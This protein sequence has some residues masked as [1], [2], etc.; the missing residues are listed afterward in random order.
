MVKAKVCEKY[1]AKT[2]ADPR[3][4]A[5]KS[6]PGSVGKKLA[7]VLSSSCCCEC[8]EVIGEDTKALQC[9]RCTVETWKCTTC[10]G[11][12]DELYDELTASSK[13]GLHWFCTKCEELV[14]DNVSPAGEKI[15]DTLGK[16]SDKTQGIEQR[17][18]ENFDLIELQ[19]VERINAV[20]QLLE[21]K[22]E[23]DT[24]QWQLVES[25]LKKLEERPAVIEEAQE[26]IEFKVDQLK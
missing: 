4:L 21:R 16:L 6:I 10:L 9:E 17:L 14:L 3:K 15:A 24:T 22:T 26:R 1:K 8:G 23:S 25:R 19:L 11:L 2:K 5:G 20:E 7:A 12:S 18:I 13:N